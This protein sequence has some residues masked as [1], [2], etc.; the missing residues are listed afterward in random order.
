MSLTQMISNYHSFC[1]NEMYY[2]DVYLLQLLSVYLP[3]KYILLNLIRKFETAK[4]FASDYKHKQT[5]DT[6]DKNLFIQNMCEEMLGTVITILIERNNSDIADVTQEEMMKQKMINLLFLKDW[7]HSQ[8]MDALTKGNF[9]FDFSLQ[10]SLDSQLPVLASESSVSGKKTFTL[11]P[12]Y[13]NRVCLLFFYHDSKEDQ[14]QSSNKL[15]SLSQTNKDILSTLLT[16]PQLP[17]FRPHLRPVL[18]LLRDPLFIHILY[19]ILERTKRESELVTECMIHQALFLIAVGIQEERTGSVTGFIESLKGANNSDYNF[20]PIL[21]GISSLPSCAE[22]SPL[23]HWINKELLSKEQLHNL[24]KKTDARKDSEKKL[25]ERGHLLQT[26]AMDNLRQQQSSFL[27][28]FA[29]LDDDYEDDYDDVVVEKP[30]EDSS[31]NIGI[32]VQ[33]LECSPGQQT[34]ACIFCQETSVAA[35]VQSHTDTGVENLFVLPAYC[36]SY[37]GLRKSQSSVQSLSESDAVLTPATLDFGVVTKSCGHSFHFSCWDRFMSGSTT[38]SSQLVISPEEYKCPLCY[39]I[40]NTIIPLSLGLRYSAEISETHEVPTFERFLN[41][42]SGVTNAKFYTEATVQLATAF[43]DCFQKLPHQTDSIKFFTD[44]SVAFKLSTKCTQVAYAG[45]TPADASHT[46]NALNNTVNYTLQAKSNEMISLERLVSEEVGAHQELVL[47]SLVHTAVISMD[48]ESHQI[49]CQ[50][51]NTILNA[52]I[53]SSSN[54]DSNLFD[55]DAFSLLVNLQFSLPHLISQVLQTIPDLS[56]TLPLL[57]TLSLH[58]F[59]LILYYRLIQVL[60]CSNLATLSAEAEPDG[61]DRD[62]LFRLWSLRR[63]ALPEK[64]RQFSFSMKSLHQEILLLLLPFIRTTCMF[65]NLLFNLPFPLQLTERSEVSNKLT[66]SDEIEILLAYLGCPS[67]M[68]CISEIFDSHSSHDL[69]RTWITSSTTTSL[70]Y[71]QFTQHPS[72]IVFPYG[73]LVTLPHSYMDIMTEAIAYDCPITLQRADEVI[74]CLVCGKCVCWSCFA[75]SET[76][77]QS[78]DGADSIGPYTDHTIKCSNGIGIGIWVK[79]ASLILLSGALQERTTGAI[80]HIPYLDQFGE[81]DK[82]LKKG[83]PLFLSQQGYKEINQFWMQHG[84]PSTIEKL[85]EEK[86]WF[87]SWEWKLY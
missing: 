36:S 32:G 80:M 77:K 7:N 70:V 13:H 62:P 59:K 67:F 9:S 18:S 72:L 60:L 54:P 43:R 34:D 25:I 82:G 16:P 3:P 10:N 52:L 41:L 55:Y 11:K 15:K 2:R 42:L 5:S 81:H 48:I 61:V 29:L 39:S 22:V 30:M 38:T 24:S 73:G 75:C 44:N 79:T 45:V 78:A 20:V 47:R 40:C 4:W 63:R 50:N 85:N 86:P 53:T 19:I 37:S 76:Y 17:K 64:L 57:P 87:K 1:C 14:S 49:R 23:I 21:A 65:Y 66:C 58:V 28:R 51:A 27:Q 84:I 46:V 69:V 56:L 12:E 35:G 26:R 68:S 31:S 8:L 6:M 33:C 71:A 74:K 83:S